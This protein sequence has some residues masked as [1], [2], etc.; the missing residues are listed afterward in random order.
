MSSQSSSNSSTFLSSSQ[1]TLSLNESKSL[2]QLRRLA[3]D[4]KNQLNAIHDNTICV[5]CSRLGSIEGIDDIDENK[6]SE[7]IRIFTLSVRNW[8]N[9]KYAS[10]GRDARSCAN[11]MHAWA[12]LHVDTNTPLY[13][14]L[15]DVAI[16][17]VSDFNAQ[18]VCNCLWSI[19]T[20]GMS[21]SS[22]ILI[23]R[24][25]S[26]CIAKVHE[27]NAQKV[28]NCLWSIAKL[29]LIASF[30]VLIPMLILQCLTIAPELK[31]QEISNIL[32]S[33]ATLRINSL[34]EDVI[35]HLLSQCMIKLQDFN[36]QT[37]SNCLWSIATLNLK[38]S[39]IE[40]LLPHLLSQCMIKV[41]ELN[42]QNISNCLWSIATLEI[43]DK[44]L[45]KHL[46]EAC[47]HRVND[48]THLDLSNC[49]WAVA[50]LGEDFAN[51]HVIQ[52]LL[53]VCTK[54]TYKFSAQ[55]V[56]M[57]FWSIAKLGVFNKEFVKEISTICVARIEDFN[58][59]QVCMCLFGMASMGI[60]NTGKLVFQVLIQA[61]LNLCRIFN[62]HDLASCLWSLATLDQVCLDDIQCHE[63]YTLLV[64]TINTRFPII[65]SLSD[66]KQCLQAHYA[67]LKLCNE[68]VDHFRLIL[69][70]CSSRIKSTISQVAVATA[71]EN[72]GYLPKLEFPIL[73]GLLS[74]DI[75]I[76]I[77]SEYDKTKEGAA[78]VS[79]LT[80]IAIEFD[81][82]NHFMRISSGPR[83]HVGPIDARTRLR[84]TLINKSGIFK[85]LIVIPY[86][87][88]DEVYSSIHTKSGEYRIG[89]RGTKVHSVLPK[90]LHISYLQRKIQ[91]IFDDESKM[92]SY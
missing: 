56:S 66:A 77:P 8:L 17:M 88:W 13:K 40:V 43:F 76:D 41:K 2:S 90:S 79:S 36:A 21:T 10:I 29:E 45:T 57:T 52:V 14:D 89:P 61:S 83:D 60:E 20:L 27:F 80:K 18:E 73:D 82:P 91:L 5:T 69:Q 54:H 6:K 63:L 33:I 86:F 31:A 15:C 23:P 92:M 65:N 58:S 46:F 67:G 11:I 47:I 1:L 62:E 3:K 37:I 9:R 81:G 32:W 22:E 4:N 12:K 51:E 16:V 25:I 72:L 53:D 49:I 87:E 84:N 70:R 44:T 24:L 39:S 55:Q 28:S 74:V 71:L 26:Q 75:V 68:A 78:A 30:E 42:P 38:M 50:T 48:M 7:A 34:C 85:G 19:A 64:L 59:K 35:P